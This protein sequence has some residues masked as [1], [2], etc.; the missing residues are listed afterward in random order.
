MKM[1][2]FFVIEKPAD[3]QAIY[4]RIYYYDED[5]NSKYAESDGVSV[6]ELEFD[7]NDEATLNIEIDINENDKNFMKTV[8]KKVPHIT[9]YGVPFTTNSK[10]FVVSVP[11]NVDT[12]HSNLTS[13]GL[14]YIDE[15]NIIRLDEETFV[16]SFLNVDTKSLF[17]TK[18]L[19]YIYSNKFEYTGGISYAKNENQQ[20]SCKAF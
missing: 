11:P 18:G 16:Y 4:Y 13:Y 8:I 9:Q 7:E 14:Y 2:R 19:A 1:D 10:T 5:S 20:I 12:S 3:N 15:N 6:A 17:H